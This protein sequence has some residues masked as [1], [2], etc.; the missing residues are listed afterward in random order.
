MKHIL[1]NEL[2]TYFCIH[3]STAKG[4]RELG[5]ALHLSPT[6]ISRLAAP[7][8]KEDLLQEKKV[9]RSRVLGA[10]KQNSRFFLWKR[11]KNVYL[12]IES[13]ILEQFEEHPV[14]SAVLFGSFRRGEDTEKSD[15]DIALSEE[16]PVD[17]AHLEKK[18]KRRLQ[19]HLLPNAPPTLLENIRQGIVLWG[20]MP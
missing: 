18:L 11:W 15:I 19:V 16:V 14:R 13:G 6:Q 8:L 4:I 17:F 1:D 10:N 9:G 3:P 5:K 7:L 12:L 20:V 2:F